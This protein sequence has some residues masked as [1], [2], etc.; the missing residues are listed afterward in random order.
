MAIG[1]K[2]YCQRTENGEQ[3]IKCKGIP[4]TETLKEEINMDVM[5]RMVLGTG[6]AVVEACKDLNFK[7]DQKSLTIQSTTLQRHISCT[8]ISRVIGQNFKTYHGYKDPL[9]SNK[10]SRL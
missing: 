2:T 9:S 8:F 10:L 4:K 7:R 5:K 6:T 3:R 1:K